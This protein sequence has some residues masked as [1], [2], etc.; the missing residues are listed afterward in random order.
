MDFSKV[1]ASVVRETEKAYQLNISYWTKAE[2]P[3]KERKTWC[4]KSCCKTEDGKVVE[5]ANFIL[6]RL[7][8][9]IVDYVK[10]YFRYPPTIRF[11]MEAK[12]MEAKRL[13]DK[14]EAER[15]EWEDSVTRIV[16]YVTPYALAFVKEV[17]TVSRIFGEHLEKVSGGAEKWQRLA[18]LGKKIEAQFGK[19]ESEA[20]VYGYVEKDQDLMLYLNQLFDLWVLGDFRIYDNWDYK[21]KEFTKGE[22]QN[23]RDDILGWYDK[24]GKLRC[25]KR[26]KPFIEAKAECKDVMRMSA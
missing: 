25:D 4:P 2:K 5:V 16:D 6:D 15:R 24:N 8:Q 22:F 9:E 20:N 17:G 13:K 23:V 14:K 10:Q 18:S 7:A 12:E 11:D 19:W 21:H 3:A 26:M 1:K